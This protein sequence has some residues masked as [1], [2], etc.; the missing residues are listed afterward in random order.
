MKKKLAALFLAL[1]MCM[2]MSAPAFAVE[3]TSVAAMEKAAHEDAVRADIMRQLEAQ[4]AMELYDAFESYFLPEET[5]SYGTYATPVR[6][7]APQGGVTSFKREVEYRGEDVTY[8]YAISHYDFDD[9]EA[10]LSHR[11]TG[12]GVWKFFQEL[13][14]SE[15]SQIEEALPKWAY[16]LLCA[17]NVAS[18]FSKSLV[19]DAGGYACSVTVDSYDSCA[20]VVAGWDEYPYAV[21]DYTDAT[22]RSFTN[23]PTN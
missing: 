1:V 10:L 18:G 14:G 5:S 22:N 15:L 3:S 11:S 20:T 19:E 23:F 9:S 17:A 13:F 12:I 4:D 16:V 8:E 6:Y 7:Y 2:T 21:I